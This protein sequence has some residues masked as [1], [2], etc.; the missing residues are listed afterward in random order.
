MD[1]IEL[2]QAARKDSPRMPII[3]VTAYKDRDVEAEAGRAGVR[4]VLHKPFDIDELVAA[5]RSSLAAA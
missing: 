3:M 2:A 4:R 5:I 1:G